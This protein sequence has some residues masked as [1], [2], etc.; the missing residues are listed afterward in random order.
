MNDFFSETRGKI[1][2]DYANKYFKDKNI[3]EVGCG[4]GER[5]RL[6]FG[7]AR[8][9]WAI[10]LKDK[11][12]KQY[13]DKF[14][15]SIGNALCIPF[16]DETFDGVVSFD[17][18]EHIFDDKKA[19]EEMTRVCK[20]NGYLMIGTPN[21]TRLSSFCYM[22]IGRKIQYPYRL[23]SD[24]LHL[25]EYIK[26]ELKNLTDRAKV[27]TIVLKCIYLGFT[28]FI[29]FGIAKI[30]KRLE[31]YGQYLFFLGQK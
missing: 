1:I 11:V 24:V 7:I 18:I 12:K 27:K 26:E 9:V 28:G 14:N 15:F 5:T 30:P 31:K 6:F 10:D 19:I 4:E 25:R 21:R 17:V 13:K 2:T 22:L 20:K 16:A 23:G 3:L 8:Q 29:N